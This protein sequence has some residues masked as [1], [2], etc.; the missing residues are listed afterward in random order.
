MA[1]AEIV[2]LGEYRDDLLE[3]PINPAIQ[4]AVEDLLVPPV[5]PWE[6]YAQA[7]RLG[8]RMLAEIEG[9]KEPEHSD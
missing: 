2:D 3:E 4:A 8:K 5:H 6:I 9:P 7:K 1:D